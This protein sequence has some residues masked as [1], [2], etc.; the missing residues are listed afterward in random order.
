MRKKFLFMI[1]LII[2]FSVVLCSFTACFEQTESSDDNSN[3][4]T[5]DNNDNDTDDSDDELT[6]PD[7][8]NDPPA[9]I[10]GFTPQDLTEMMSLSH[11]V[12]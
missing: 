9:P 3:T 10:Y 2:I 6:D 12:A 5:G 4:A 11:N 8:E 1:A 7:D